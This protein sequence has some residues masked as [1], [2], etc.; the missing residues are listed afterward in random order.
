MTTSGLPPLPT[1]VIHV[2]A[3]RHFSFA[4]FVILVYDHLLTFGDEV[5]LIWSQ[6]ASVV[7]VIFVVNRYLAPVVLA[8]DIYD[9]GG[10]T[11]HVSRTFCRNWVM[12]EGYLN[13]SLLAAV[14][15]SPS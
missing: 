1:I 5:E 4:G 2:T 9:K 14:C 12:V 3:S 11:R 10:L 13:L 8:I 7:S 15:I 6:P